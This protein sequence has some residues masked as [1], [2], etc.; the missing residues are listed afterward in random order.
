M[1]DIT[2]QFY[3]RLHQNDIGIVIS[4]NKLE[5]KQNFPLQ[6]SHCASEYES[7]LLQPIRT[8]IIVKH[9]VYNQQSQSFLK[10][11]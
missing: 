2:K 1:L 5:R 3:V 7:Q 11:H 10:R 9:S 4:N 8:I 6:I